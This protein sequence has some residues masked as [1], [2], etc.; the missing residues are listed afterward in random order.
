M[1]QNSEPVNLSVGDLQSVLN[2][3]DLCTQRGSF[4]AS[5]LEG[6]GRLYNHI[7]RFVQQHQPQDTQDTQDTN[8]SQNS[9]ENESQ[10]S[11]ENESQ[12][13][14]ENENENKSKVNNIN[15]KNL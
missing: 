14:Q 8:E 12:N 1:T 10:N 4:R 9:Q 15:T 13:S 5:E 7:Y 2:I 11:Q 6:V 3:M